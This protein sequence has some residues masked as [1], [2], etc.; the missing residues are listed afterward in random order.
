MSKRDTVLIISRATAL[1][2]FCWAFDAFSYLPERLMD[3]QRPMSADLHRYYMLATELTV[4]RGVVFL[5]TSDAAVT[6]VERGFRRSC[7]LR[8]SS[9]T[10]SE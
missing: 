3:I 2:L 4:L 8:R 1:Y 7:C 10:L 9:Q 6:N 5:R